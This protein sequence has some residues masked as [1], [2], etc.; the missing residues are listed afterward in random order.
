MNPRDRLNWP[1][2]FFINK[3]K[4]NI[5]SQYYYRLLQSQNKSAVENEM[6][7]EE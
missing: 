5:A 4:R 1:R 3:K 7:G 2:G 6:F